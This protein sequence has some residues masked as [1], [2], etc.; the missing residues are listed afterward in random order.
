MSNR[1]FL[2]VQLLDPAL[3]KGFFQLFDLYAKRLEQG[4][5]KILVENGLF[6]VEGEIWKKHRKIDSQA[7]HLDF[8]K[9]QI[10]LIQKVAREFIS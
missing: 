1:L 5:I 2:Q 10:S 6:S 9:D 4:Y 7:F 8:I 3:L